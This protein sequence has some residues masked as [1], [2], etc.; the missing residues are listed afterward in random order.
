MDN[1]RKIIRDLIKEESD[2]QMD[3]GDKDKAR[4]GLIALSKGLI[5]S[6][7]IK[8]IK[9]NLDETDRDEDGHYDEAGEVEIEYVFEHTKYDIAIAITGSYYYKAGW[10]G[11]YNNPPDHDT[12]EDEEI[13]VDDDDF[14]LG[15]DERNEY[16]FHASELGPS[17]HKD[18]ES[19]LV[20]YYDV[21]ESSIG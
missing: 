20:D 14:I 4:R 8:R 21:S 12:F 9:G 7:E 17:F 16:E 18:M 13:T 10:G 5:P 3:F 6:N 11:D 19:F 1:L 2:L 15:D